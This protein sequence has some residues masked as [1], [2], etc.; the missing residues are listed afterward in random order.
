MQIPDAG[1]IAWIDFDPVLGA[2]QAGRRPALVLT[3]RLYHEQSNRSLVCPITS[4][5]RDWPTEVRLPPGLKTKGTVLVDQIRV[6]D[7]GQRMF[8]TIE[9]VPDAVLARVRRSLAAL[10]GIE[11]S[12]LRHL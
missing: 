7:R 3:S 12:T 6:V 5:V 8:D 2:E 10:T 4:R 9:R 11:I 1:D